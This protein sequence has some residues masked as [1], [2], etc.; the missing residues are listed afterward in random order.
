MD[1]RIIIFCFLTTC[2]EYLVYSFPDYNNYNYNEYSSYKNDG[3][4]SKEDQSGESEVFGESAELALFSGEADV[5]DKDEKGSLFNGTAKFEIISFPTILAREAEFEGSDHHVARSD[6]NGTKIPVYEKIEAP[7]RRPLALSRNYIAKVTDGGGEGS[8]LKLAQHVEPSNKTKKTLWKGKSE[9]SDSKNRYPQKPDDVEMILPH[10]KTLYLPMVNGKPKPYDGYRA[11]PDAEGVHQSKNI[12]VRK[13]SPDEREKRFGQG[14]IIYGRPRVALRPE[15]LREKRSPAEYHGGIHPYYDFMDSKLYWNNAE[16]DPMQNQYSAASTAEE[17]SELPDD[18]F[19]SKHDFSNSF[20]YEVEENNGEGEGEGLENEGFTS[21]ENFDFGSEDT[22]ASLEGVEESKKVQSFAVGDFKDFNLDSLLSLNRKLSEITINTEKK[23]NADL[24]KRSSS[25]A[26]DNT[27]GTQ[28]REQKYLCDG[29]T[30][31]YCSRTNSGKHE[32][33]HQRRKRSAK[34]AYRSDDLERGK[35]E[36]S[37]NTGESSDAEYFTRPRKSQ[38]NNSRQQQFSSLQDRSGHSKNPF[39]NHKLLAQRSQKFSFNWDSPSSI[40]NRKGSDRQDE[41]AKVYGGSFTY[42]TSG[43][44]YG[45]PASI[46]EGLNFESSEETSEPY[47]NYSDEEET[48]NQNYF[49]RSVSSDRYFSEYKSE[50]EKNQRDA[51]KTK[52][53][54]T[55]GPSLKYSGNNFNDRRPQHQKFSLKNIFHPE[56]AAQFSLKDQKQQ[57]KPTKEDDREKRGPQRYPPSQS[58]TAVNTQ[59]QGGQ[60]KRVENTKVLSERGPCEIE[61]RGKTICKVCTDEKTSAT[62]EQCRFSTSQQY[63]AFDHKKSIK[64]PS[65]GFAGSDQKPEKSSDV[66]RKAVPPSTTQLPTRPSEVTAATNKFENSDGKKYLVGHGQVEPED[67]DSFLKRLD[68]REILGDEH[69]DLFEGFSFDMGEGGEK[70]KVEEEKHESLGEEDFG[71]AFLGLGDDDEHHHDEKGDFES[72]GFFG[73]ESFDAHEFDH[74]NA[75]F[76]EGEEHKEGEGGGEGGA[77]EGGGHE[78]SF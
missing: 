51:S 50:N 39:N 18:F 68:R 16:P 48:R 53:Y 41:S 27:Q 28:G 42:D 34:F 43:E 35:N 8:R 45:V 52:G 15:H 61:R 74:L 77:G 44:T 30:K 29:K 60:G 47:N 19:S 11:A 3:V 32:N 64:A 38:K 7:L 56:A 54:D 63:T 37:R 6:V 13:E 2:G 22:S 75:D 17:K 9:Q 69:K 1:K 71:E 62:Y 40:R 78:F 73:F 36:N 24:L 10:H 55:P 4:Y 20:G 76:G 57:P 49:H 5:K 58:H 72:E 33:S 67:L 12:R 31:G 26:R 23:K 70:H 25:H 59:K 66:E 21:G 46:Y 65:R 14:E